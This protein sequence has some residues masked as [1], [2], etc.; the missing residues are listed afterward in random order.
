[1]H[2]NLWHL[3]ESWRTPTHHSVKDPS[4]SYK[5]SNS[6]LYARSINLVF[7]VNGSNESSI[8]TA[9][10]TQWLSLDDSHHLAAFICERMSQFIGHSQIWS[11][12][13]WMACGNVNSQWIFMEQFNL[14]FIFASEAVFIVNAFIWSLGM[15]TKA[16]SSPR[17]FSSPP[18][19]LPYI[20]TYK[21][22]VYM[23][24]SHFMQDWVQ[25][26]GIR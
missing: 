20:Y 14:Q 1:M 9:S 8:M 10:F 7:R 13:R 21:L 3:I 23:Y 25:T 17:I 12:S 6:R 2:S 15:N 4:W 16:G 5:T 24:I 11:I 19:I 26:Q 18:Y 22:Y